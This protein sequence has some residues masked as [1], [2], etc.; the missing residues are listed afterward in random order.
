M[1]MIL[2]NKIFSPCMLRNEFEAKLESM[3]VE[4]LIICNV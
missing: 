4:Y 2:K 3:I 1:I